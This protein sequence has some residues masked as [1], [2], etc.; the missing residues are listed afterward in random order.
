[1]M[2]LSMPTV[3]TKYLRNQMCMRRCRLRNAGNSSRKRSELLTLRIFITCDGANFGGTCRY[4]CMRSGQTVPSMIVMSSRLRSYKD[5]FEPRF[6]LFHQDI[7]AAS[8][9]LHKTALS[10][11][12]RMRRPV[13]SFHRNAS[14]SN[15]RQLVIAQQQCRFT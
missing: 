5:S 10:A 15:L 3:I 11:I 13:V 6:H 8:R 9:Y 7:T 2:S 4:L 1:M 14:D 12:D